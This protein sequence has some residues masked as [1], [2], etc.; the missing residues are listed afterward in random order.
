M[1]TD[2]IISKTYPESHEMTSSF[3]LWYGKE[4]G[5]KDYIS[6]FSINAEVLL[7]FPV[8]ISLQLLFMA[9]SFL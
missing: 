8:F 3:V 6:G 9:T 1:H 2:A 7:F 5:L 4:Q